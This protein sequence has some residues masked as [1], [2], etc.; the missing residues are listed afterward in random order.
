MSTMTAEY[1]TTMEQ[2]R[3]AR[4]CGEYQIAMFWIGQARV[5]RS[6]IH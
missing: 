5:I 6:R 4:E 3:F 1:W 2:A